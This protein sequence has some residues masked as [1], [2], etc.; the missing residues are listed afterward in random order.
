MQILRAGRTCRA[1]DALR[2][3]DVWPSISDCG[4]QCLMLVTKGGR[5]QFSLLSC[6]CLPSRII[7]EADRCQV[8][9]SNEC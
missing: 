9:G 6:L 4:G 5:S 7:S 1:T 3:P 2:V 8:R